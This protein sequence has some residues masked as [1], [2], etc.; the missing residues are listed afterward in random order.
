MYRLVVKNTFVEIEEAGSSC[1]RRRSSSCPPAVRSDVV[2]RGEK[3]NANRMGRPWGWGISGVA[4]IVEKLHV[5]CRSLALHHPTTI[6]PF[7][8]QPHFRF[9]SA[10]VDVESQASDM[11][12]YF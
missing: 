2:R 3:P 8:R 10:V 6:V 7:M 11:H 4:F 12:H 1:A 9:E 5:S